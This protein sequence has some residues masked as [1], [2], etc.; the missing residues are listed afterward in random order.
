MLTVL[1]IANTRRF[2]GLDITVMTSPCEQNFLVGMMSCRGRGREKRT[3][4]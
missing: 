1:Q 3:G 4:K 2:V